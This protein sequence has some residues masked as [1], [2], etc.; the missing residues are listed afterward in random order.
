MVNKENV[1][2]LLKGMGDLVTVDMGRAEL[3]Q[4]LCLVKGFKEDKKDQQWMKVESGI[5]CE[6]STHTSPCVPIDHTHSAEI[7]LVSLH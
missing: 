5:T 3:P 4:P 1:G 7:W 2:P 6:E